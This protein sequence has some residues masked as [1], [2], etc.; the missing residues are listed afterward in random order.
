MTTYIN[1]FGGP[2]AGKSTTAA[3]VFYNMK[4]LGLKVELVTEVAKDFVWE[5]R[6]DTLMIQP[7]VT[8]KQYRNLVRLKG[9]V[10]YVITDAPIL[11][12]IL[13]ANKYAQNLPA[14]YHQFVS[15]CHRDILT[16]SV[17]ILLERSYAYDPVGRYQT[18]D[19]AHKLDL[20]IEQIMKDASVT[21]NKVLP[22]DAPLFVEAYL[23]IKGMK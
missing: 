11:F 6:M 2:G 23:S 10:D 3:A 12:G 1:I 20:E 15:D 7:Y 4:R 17:N 18:E 19:E 16:P 14:S 5:N 9:K 21:Y 22:N 8:M 13:Y